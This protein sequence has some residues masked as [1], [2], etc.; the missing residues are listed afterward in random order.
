MAATLEVLAR[1]GRFD[2]VGTQE[3]TMIEH[4]AKIM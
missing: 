4:I 3:N 1:A 2:R